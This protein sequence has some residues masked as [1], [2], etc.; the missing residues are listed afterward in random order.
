M[1]YKIAVA[2][3]DGKVVNEHFG[4]AETFYI[5][6]G[7]TEDKEKIS[8]IDIRNVQSFC[9]GGRHNDGQFENVLGK[10][11]DCQYVLV[12]RIGY[13]AAVELEVRGFRAFELP[14][15]IGESVAE[16]LNYLEVQKLT[17]NILQERG[18]GNE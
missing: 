7:D 11:A 17:E 1:K 10:I 8:L 6:E 2:S 18:H 12:S 15:I 4:R 16:L 9:E 5:V 13:R 14:G 3:T